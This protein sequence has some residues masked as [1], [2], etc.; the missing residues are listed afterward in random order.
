MPRKKTLG[1]GSLAGAI[2]AVILLLIVALGARL[3]LE[4][5]GV[6]GRWRIDG[7]MP[8]HLG[9]GAI[10]PVIEL[11]IPGN[12][13]EAVWT[14]ALA[15]RLGGRAEAKVEFGRIDVLTETYAIEIDFLKKWKEGVGQS[16]HYANATGKTACLALIVEHEG[17]DV[18]KEIAYVDKLCLEKGI[19][20]VLLIRLGEADTR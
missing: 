20:L 9:G 18:V 12:S 5:P 8:A 17:A 2:A 7:N 16:L 3:G 4:V 6:D 1:R 19:K 11:D 14:A 13:K 15:R 10:T